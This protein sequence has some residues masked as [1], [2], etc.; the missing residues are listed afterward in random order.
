MVRLGETD[1]NSDTDCNADSSICSPA[2]Q[3]YEIDSIISHRDYDVPKYANDIALI[4]LRQSTNASSNYGC[5]FNIKYICTF[6]SIL[7]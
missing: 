1:A 4:R 3:D 6:G 5:T 7:T 2:P